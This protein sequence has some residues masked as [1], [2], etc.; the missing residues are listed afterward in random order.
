MKNII[1]FLLGV[2]V[3]SK[4]VYVQNINNSKRPRDLINSLSKILSRY[5]ARHNGQ[6]VLSLS[7]DLERSFISREFV[8]YVCR[9]QKIS[10]FYFEL[11]AKKAMLAETFIKNIKRLYFQ[12]KAQFDLD[13]NG[14][15]SYPS[16]SKL[17]QTLANKLN[18]RQIS[19]D[20]KLIE[21]KPKT[22][23]KGNVNRYMDEV[24][25]L[26]PALK[27]G[28]FVIDSSKYNFDNLKVGDIVK[29]KRSFLSYDSLSRTK[30]TEA[31][32]SSKLYQIDKLFVYLSKDLYINGGC[33]VSQFNPIK[34]TARKE[35]YPEKYFFP[36]E[37]IKV[38]TKPTINKLTSK[39]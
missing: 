24:K 34:S 18:E 29:I 15:K 4:Y 30:R 37:A 23:N 3:V 39:N 21:V 5:R 10:L 28:S 27:Y 22:I 6:N 13:T 1:G 17:L 9:N 14:S 38:L 2:D 35:G 20:G 11:N 19:V 33:L 16:M 7:V 36:I 8:N 31:T 25:K 12:N 32:L 26:C